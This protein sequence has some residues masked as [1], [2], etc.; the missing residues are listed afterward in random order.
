[1]VSAVNGTAGTIEPSVLASGTW[2]NSSSYRGESMATAVSNVGGEGEWI[3]SDPEAE[4]AH[5]PS[6][7]CSG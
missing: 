2:L 6:V 3:D 5:V 4:G 1:V 7:E